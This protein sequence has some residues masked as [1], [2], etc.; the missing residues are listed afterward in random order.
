ME[1][2]SLL[3]H[4]PRS[5]RI[6]VAGIVFT[7]RIIDKL[8]ASLPGG[9]LNGY[10]ALSGFSELWAH[11]TGI[12][13]VDMQRCVVRA[14]SEREVEAWL[15][16]RTSHLDLERINGKMERFNSGRTPESLRAEFERIYPAELRERHPLLFDLLEADDARLYLLHGENAEFDAVGTPS[17][18]SD[19][20]G[21][22]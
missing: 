9:E 20:D 19:E 14:S 17:T 10:L 13:L 8:R 18:G 16:E 6:K 21:P 1:P 12:D 3:A 5:P 15:L 2:L 7:A 4:P 22:R 11:Y